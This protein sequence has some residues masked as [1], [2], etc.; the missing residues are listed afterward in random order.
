MSSSAA[1]SPEFIRHALTQYYKS[2][3][4]ERDAGD[5]VLIE[6]KYRNKNDNYQSLVTAMNETYEKAFKLSLKTYQTWKEIQNMKN[7][8]KTLT[9]D[10][11]KEPPTYSP[12]FLALAFKQYFPDQSQE[13]I[14]T[15]A[16]YFGNQ[17][18][19]KTLTAWLKKKNISHRLPRHHRMW[20]RR[21]LKNEKQ[22][23]DDLRTKHDNELV[24]QKQKYKTKLQDQKRAQEGAQAALEKAQTALQQCRTLLQKCRNKS[25]TQQSADGPAAKPSETPSETSSETASAKASALSPAEPEAPFKA[26]PFGGAV[27]TLNQRNKGW[28]IEFTPTKFNVDDENTWPKFVGEGIG[29]IPFRPLSTAQID[30]KDWYVEYSAV[31]KKPVYKN[32]TDAPG[33]D[34]GDLKK[35]TKTQSSA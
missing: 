32:A 28:R 2:I 9:K 22:R 19:N 29:E 7:E 8:L 34:Y 4:I 3:D 16:T 31:R 21:T 10:Q 33:A 35:E 30:K 24:K 12:E 14:D 5:I 25:K 13:S 18:D 11:S 15:M 26:A 6:K 20:C 23:E 1:Y 17:K 27:L